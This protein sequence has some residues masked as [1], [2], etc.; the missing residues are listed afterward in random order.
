MLYALH[1]FVLKLVKFFS[2]PVFNL[3]NKH[4][5]VACRIV[6]IP[7]TWS[8]LHVGQGPNAGLLKGDF[9]CSSWQDF[10]WHSAS[11]RGPSATG[12]PV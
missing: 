8:D 10:N 6:A 2:V 1:V 5:H 4:F 11:S 9:L 7:I 12:E 3:M